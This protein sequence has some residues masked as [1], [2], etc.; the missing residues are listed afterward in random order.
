MVERDFVGFDC[1]TGRQVVFSHMDALVEGASARFTVANLTSS[2]SG[3]PLALPYKRTL[4]MAIS[5]MDTS[6]SVYASAMQTT[7][8]QR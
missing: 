1:C 2:A 5:C 4:H 3:D 7:P 8:L 6:E